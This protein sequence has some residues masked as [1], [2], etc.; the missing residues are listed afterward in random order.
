MSKQAWIHIVA[1]KPSP[2]PGPSPPSCLSKPSNSQLPNALRFVSHTLILTTRRMVM[3][4]LVVRDPP[5]LIPSYL[6]LLRRYARLVLAR[7][8]SRDSLRDRLVQISERAELHLVVRPAEEHD[9][10]P[11]VL[12]LL[13]RRRAGNA[14]ARQLRHHAAPRYRTLTRRGGCWSAECLR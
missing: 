5:R 3:A 4:H 8:R 9:R 1:F 6:P 7:R 2:H 14:Y 13:L 10:V 12:R 11:V